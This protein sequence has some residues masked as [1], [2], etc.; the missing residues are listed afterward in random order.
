MSTHNYFILFINAVT[1]LAKCNF[2][3][4]YTSELASVVIRSDSFLVVT[5]V[6]ASDT[7]KCYVLC[8]VYICHPTAFGRWMLV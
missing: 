1:E 7:L 3:S 5:S 4:F 2:V 6:N 8:E